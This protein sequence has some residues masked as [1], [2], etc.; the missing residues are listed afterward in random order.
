[1]KKKTPHIGYYTLNNNKD[2]WEIKEFEGGG[3][4]MDC[5]GD[6]DERTGKV[7]GDFL[8]FHETLPNLDDY[9]LS[10]VEY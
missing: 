7:P 2:I 3:K 9:D 6:Y 4:Y 10:K 8:L 5:Y 1:M